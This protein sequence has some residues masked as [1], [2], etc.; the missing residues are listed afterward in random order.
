MVYAATTHKY[1]IDYHPGDVYYCTAD[2]GWV[3]GTILIIIYL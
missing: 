1:I 2:L 3:T